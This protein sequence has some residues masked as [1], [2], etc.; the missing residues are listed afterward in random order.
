MSTIGEVVRR[1]SQSI[2]GPLGPESRAEHPEEREL[3]IYDVI[4]EEFDRLDGLEPTK[5]RERSWTVRPEHIRDLPD[6]AR[7][8][9]NARTPLAVPS[10]R[11]ATT[12]DATREISRVL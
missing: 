11:A 4:E 7:K 10:S 2:F 6:L 3:Q 1:S 9:W 12:S 8:L 5:P